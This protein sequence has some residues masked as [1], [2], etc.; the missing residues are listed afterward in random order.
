MGEEFK[1]V[2]RGAVG[3]YSSAMKLNKSESERAEDRAAMAKGRGKERQLDWRLTD[4]SWDLTQ[5][6]SNFCQSP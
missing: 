6:W 4:G 1:T 2:S 5:T 3:T